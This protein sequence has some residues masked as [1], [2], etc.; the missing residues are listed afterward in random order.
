MA[1]SSSA[2]ETEILVCSCDR[3]RDVWPAFFT[4]FFRYWPDCPFRINLLANQCS[5]PDPRVRTLHTPV[6]ADWSTT[7]QL[8]LRQ[9]ESRYVLVTVEDFLLDRAVDTARV[10][11]LV[12]LLA[13][14]GA[15][16]VHLGPDPLPERPLRGA[17][18][19][20][21]VVPGQAFRVNLQNAVW[22]R[23]TLLELVVSGESA[24]DFEVKGT[25]RSVS[26][27]AP[28]LS[29]RCAELD[30]PMHYFR[31]GVAR[32]KWMPGA[33]RLCRREGIVVDTRQRPVGWLR[34]VARGIPALRPLRE[35]FVWIRRR[36]GRN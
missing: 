26:V 15:A 9:V 31:T 34:G 35:G 33:V 28:F 4:L 23:K 5:Y 16:C 18:G 7:F 13:Q 19:V 25:E 24:W 12:E 10:V 22:Q 32:G 30:A 36:L 11:E 27:E 6:E 8:A 1:A 2:E 17:P 3:Y 14:L 20:G 21:V 29:L